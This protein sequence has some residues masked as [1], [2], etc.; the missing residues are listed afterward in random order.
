MIDAARASSPGSSQQVGRYR[1]LAPIASGGTATVYLGRSEAIGGFSRTVAVKLLHP[2]LLNDS[3]SEAS[4]EFLEEAKLSARMQHPLIVPVLDVGESEQGFYL[5]MEYVDGASLAE[6]LRLE[7]KLPRR[8]A[9]RILIDVLEALQ[10]AHSAVDDRD[11]SLGIVHRDFSPQNI[12]VGSDGRSRLTDFGIAKATSR[13]EYTRTGLIKGKIAYMSPEQA[14][15]T[16]LDQR[17]DVWAAGVVAW[18]MFAGHRMYPKLDPLPHLLRIIN[19]EAPSLSAVNPELPAALVRAIHSALVRAP[20][21]RTP[22]AADL[23]SRLCSALGGLSELASHAEVGEF[24]ESFRLDRLTSLRAVVQ[25][26][27]SEMASAPRSRTQST[28]H[29]FTTVRH[30]SASPSTG[31]SSFV[32]TKEPRTPSFFPKQKLPNT[33]GLVLA[34]LLLPS[35]VLLKW[36]ETPE[37]IGA[38]AGEFPPQAELLTLPASTIPP[39]VEAV[40]MAPLKVEP[41]LDTAHE[42]ASDAKPPSPLTAPLP[43]P[44]S[45]VPAPPNL[46][47]RKAT[48]PATKSS[49]LAPSPY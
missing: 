34:A 28:R 44:R 38:L 23:S 10:A 5:V 24:L 17:S 30:A 49:R 29:D 33:W 11:L 14:E 35:L 4:K 13:A 12:L 47:N 1:L 7:S 40:E 32:V 48:P 16:V 31:E 18:E 25:E 46:A 27:S 26:A 20:Q 15:G 42:T 21:D 37:A 2:H 8:I 3:S 43:A 9:G 39:V 19:R 36:T 6:L 41:S 45:Q 22:S